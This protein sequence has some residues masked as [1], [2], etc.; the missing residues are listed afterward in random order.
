MDLQRYPGD[1]PI[2]PKWWQ[3]QRNRRLAALA[4]GMLACLAILIIARHGARRTT[5]VARA[6]VTIAVVT[7]GLF[8]DDIALRARAVALNSIYL[9]A[10]QGGRVEQVYAH[11]GDNVVQGQLL[12]ELSNSQ[13]ELDV[14]E[15]EAR[16][17]ESV[18]Q[19]ETYQTQLE[20]N[21][22]A[23]ARTLALIDYNITRLRHSL[24][25]RTLLADVE[26][27]ETREQVSDELDYDLRVEPLQADSNH[28]QEDLRLAQLPQIQDQLR[29]LQ[30]DLHLTHA[31]LDK[32]MVRAPITGRLTGMSAQG[33]ENKNIGDRIG[34]ITADDGFRLTAE[35][36]E[37]YVGRVRSGQRASVVVRDH[38]YSLAVSRIYPQVK[39]GSFSIDLDFTGK[40]PAELTLGES[41]QGKLTLGEDRNSLILQVGAFLDRT[42]GD[43]AYVLARDRRVAERRH[44]KLG[45]RSAEQLEVLS[46][47]VA[48]DSALISSYDNLGDVERVI[49]TP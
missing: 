44:I 32:L 15:R 10:Q 46:G 7:Q 48:G 47:L 4:S 23:N 5:R 6:E 28:R 26:P 18:S 8:H 2:N 42:G 17:V 25:R 9:D 12:V 31:Q 38:P 45:R 36:D 30:Q 22:V 40:P 41:V 35:V 39:E 11:A 29:S 3:R 20:Q 37:Y 19:L 21:R 14:L 27:K 34:E 1:R 13:L 16:L 43:W 49:L 24:T 33:G